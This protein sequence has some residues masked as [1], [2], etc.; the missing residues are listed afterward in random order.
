LI[1]IS[2]NHSKTLRLTS[3]TPTDLV[4]SWSTPTLSTSPQDSSPRSEINPK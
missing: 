2:I 1:Q 4:K 3:K